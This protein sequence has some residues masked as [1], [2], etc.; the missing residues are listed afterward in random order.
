MIRR[1]AISRGVL[2]GNRAFVVLGVASWLWRRVRSGTEKAEYHQLA[3]K[4]GETITIAGS[5][6]PT[7]RERRRRS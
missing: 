4:P 1:M 6:R 3:I 5:R 2:G 7:R